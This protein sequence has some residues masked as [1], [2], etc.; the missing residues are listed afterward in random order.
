MCRILGAGCWLCWFLYLDVLRCVCVCASLLKGL[1]NFVSKSYTAMLFTRTSDLIC[2]ASYFRLVISTRL[3]VESMSIALMQPAVLSC[4]VYLFC[5]AFVLLV[6]PGHCMFLSIVHLLSSICIKW[7][8]CLKVAG[9]VSSSCFSHL[10][11]ERWSAVNC[12]EHLMD[13]LP[14]NSCSNSDWTSA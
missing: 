6:F 8:P 5:E 1:G 10:S 14:L 11:D 12:F 13:T 9:L 4:G 7:V 2:G 3:A